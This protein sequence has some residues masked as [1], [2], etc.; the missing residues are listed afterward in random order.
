[1]FQ[2]HYH[3]SGLLYLSDYGTDFEGISACSNGML[4]AVVQCVIS[5]VGFDGFYGPFHCDSQMRADGQVVCS[6]S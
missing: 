6:R 1:M 2:A 4:C 3:F 5:S